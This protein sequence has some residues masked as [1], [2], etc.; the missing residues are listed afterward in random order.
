MRL[1]A[2]MSGE[3]IEEW[4]SPECLRLHEN[5]RVAPVSLIVGIISGVPVKPA[6]DP[7]LVLAPGQ[8]A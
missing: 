3:F 5:I 1:Y 7:L 4:R 2:G 6:I 8:L